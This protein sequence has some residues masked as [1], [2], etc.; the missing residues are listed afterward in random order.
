LAYWHEKVA[1]IAG[2]FSELVDAHPTKFVDALLSTYRVSGSDKELSGT[3]FTLS[4]LQNSIQQCENEI[5]QLAGV[6][7]EWSEAHQ[8][9]NNMREVR[10]WIKEVLCLATVDPE[11]LHTSYAM[12]QLIFQV[13][14]K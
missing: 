11:G 6:G 13:V 5:L 1:Q 14:Y 2:K 12:K 8:L 10:G 9:S 3:M 4:R 7:S